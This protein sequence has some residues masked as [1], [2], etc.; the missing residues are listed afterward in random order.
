MVRKEKERF[1]P[2]CSLRISDVVK[3]VS[4]FPRR[5]GELLDM[6]QD[7]D[8]TMRDRASAT[9]ARLVALHPERLPRYAPRLRE[10]LSDES[11]YVRWHLVYTLGK[12]Y[13]L[14]PERLKGALAD[15]NGRLQ[16]PNKIV[17]ALA[18]KA[19]A[20][21]ACRN[22][23]SVR[24]LFRNAEREIPRIVKNILKASGSRA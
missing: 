14:Y 5:L 24:E 18:A 3:A 9:L 19:L 20:R 11:A 7:R 4:V 17:R 15:L 13:E 16:D 21:A 10:A 6:L 12:L 1:A 23:G 8:R 2:L 22:P